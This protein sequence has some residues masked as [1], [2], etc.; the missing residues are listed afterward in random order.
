[1]KPF[2]LRSIRPLS[3]ASVWDGNA[4][5][6][7]YAQKSHHFPAIAMAYNSFDRPVFFREEDLI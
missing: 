1:M 7:A 6:D 2:P 5:N 3:H 4:R